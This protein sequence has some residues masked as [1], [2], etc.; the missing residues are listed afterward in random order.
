MGKVKIP[1]T[2]IEQNE[3]IKKNFVAHNEEEDNKFVNKEEGTKKLPNKAFTIKLNPK[4]Y[5]D[6]RVFCASN[7]LRIST[8]FNNMMENFIKNELKVEKGINE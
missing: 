5:R 3:K 6:I 1:K 2:R 7:D 4:L 8:V